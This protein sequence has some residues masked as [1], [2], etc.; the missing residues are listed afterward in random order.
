MAK[1]RTAD[2]IARCKFS[3]RMIVKHKPM[4]GVINQVR[5]F[6]AHRL[7][8]QE[9][10]GI[11]LGERCRVKLN[12]LQIPQNRPGSMGNRDPVSRTHLWIGCLG[13]HLTAAARGQDDRS[14]RYLPDLPVIEQP[15]PLG[16]AILDPQVQHKRWRQNFNIRLAEH[17]L[18]QG[19]DHSAARGVGG[20]EDSATGMGGL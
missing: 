12:K 19:R 20:M 15:H 4:S 3:V 5:P 18:G 9:S 11:D 7:A 2:D 17:M 16:H 8:D 1:N 10:R 6:P 13:K 14:R